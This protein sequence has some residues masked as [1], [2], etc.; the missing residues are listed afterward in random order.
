MYSFGRALEEL[1]AAHRRAGATVRYP[2]YADVKWKR[3]LYM[4]TTKAQ[5][6]WATA[7]LAAAADVLPAD[8]Y[9]MATLSGHPCD[10]VRFRVQST[11]AA[12][13]AAKTTTP[14]ASKPP[15]LDGVFY[16]KK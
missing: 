13:A 2:A 12:A 14:A 8:G 9:P 3:M 5:L 1:Q 7:S 11:T 16:W 6:V 10:G 15:Y 4:P